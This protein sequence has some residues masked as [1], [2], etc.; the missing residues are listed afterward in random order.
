[1]ASE[2]ILFLNFYLKFLMLQIW[3]SINE[4]YMKKI[5]HKLKKSL[6]IIKLFDYIDYL[7]KNL[8]K[9]HINGNKRK[10]KI[11]IIFKKISKA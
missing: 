6:L 9:I 3:L 5:A 8:K 2:K 11:G 7:A 4:M 1:M 10:I